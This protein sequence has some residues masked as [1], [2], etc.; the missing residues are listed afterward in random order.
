V[1]LLHLTAPK[2]TAWELLVAVVVIIVAPWLAERVHVPGLIGLLVGGMIIGPNVLDVV[3]SSSGIVKE[4][5][6]VGLLYLMFMAGLDLD[7]AVFARYRNHAIVFALITFAIPMT[8][9]LISGSF[10]GY[11]LSASI[12]LGSLFASHTLVSYAAIR[13][14]GLA[15]NRAVATAVGATVITDT[16]AL[17]VLAVVSGT[18]TGQASGFELVIQVALGLLILL[19][20]CF[21][22]LPI[23]SRWFFRTIGHERTL[24]YVYVLASLLAA[25]TV[26]EVVGIEPIVGAFFAGLALNR[27]VPNEGEFMEKIEFY[28]SSL[29]IPM[30]LVSVG[31]VIDPSVLLNW[32]T[33]GVASVFAV[34]CIGGK[35]C[36]SLTTKP[37]FGYSWDE[38]GVTFSLSVAQAAATL[39][40]TFIGLQIGLLDTSAV[41]AIMLVII[42]SLLASSITA[43]R[44]GLRIPPPPTDARR[45]GR[46]VLVH[47]DEPRDV[48]ATLQVAS[49]LVEADGGVLRPVVI[50]CDGLAP[51]ESEAIAVAARAI[52]RLGLDAE[53]ETRFDRSVRDGLLHGV[54]SHNSSFVV[55]PAATESWLPALL[56][57]SQHALVAESP[58]PVALVRG[59]TGS[60]HRA[61]LVLSSSQARRPRSAA[62]LAVDVAA[63]MHKAGLD[64]VIVADGEPVDGLLHGLPTSRLVDSVGAAWIEATG[65]DTDLVIV[66]GGRNGAL[67]T[68]RVT[69]QATLRG[70]TIAVV[71]D[72]SAVSALDAAGQ[73]LG[74][75]AGRAAQQYEVTA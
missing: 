53:V 63:R 51:P 57:A 55:V 38:V 61:V 60:V 24:R 39:A 6:D 30:F 15:T 28:G 31:T 37:L 14:M 7:L 35:L 74:L 72:S 67:A 64:L 27:L 49:R 34:A 25:A 52:G 69:K 41:N 16:M 59:G 66:P 9:G 68:A 29:L 12:L 32:G 46:S 17:I 20:F 44:Y 22:L 21:G 5:G 65:H 3:Q 47:I 8:F 43:R 73:G 62:R 42:L 19:A 26:A 75:V 58:V 11:Q 71:A 36:A 56:G 40:A 70:A 18:T 45:L 2:G 54:A 1:D 13:S 23:L 10:L 33:I 50:A 4:L 48:R